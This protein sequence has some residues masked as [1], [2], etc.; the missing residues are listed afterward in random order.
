MPVKDE[1]SEFG[2]KAHK[3]SGIQPAAPVGSEV[4]HVELTPSEKLRI[5]YTTGQDPENA[6]QSIGVIPGAFKDA[7]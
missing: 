7:Q 2:G 6:D 5:V 1:P 3:A 4:G